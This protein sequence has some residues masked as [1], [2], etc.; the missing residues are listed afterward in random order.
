MEVV[1][2]QLVRIFHAWEH[3]FQV[4]CCMLRHH[5]SQLMVHCCADPTVTDGMSSIWQK[6]QQSIYVYISAT[7]GTELASHTNQTE[8]NI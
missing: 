8:S 3:V 6:L 2:A 1:S 5:L 7:R 4:N